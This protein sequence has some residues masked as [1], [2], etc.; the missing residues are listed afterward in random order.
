MLLF[1]MGYY[2][3]AKEAMYDLE[4]YMSKNDCSREDFERV[5]EYTGHTH[6]LREIKNYMMAFKRVGTG[7]ASA[8]GGALA[9]NIAS[10]FYDSSSTRGIIGGLGAIAVGALFSKPIARAGLDTALRTG[11]G[12]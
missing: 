4:Q 9:Y 7:I 1:A 6:S 11:V 12:D 8:M 10:S 2:G 3:N 5:R